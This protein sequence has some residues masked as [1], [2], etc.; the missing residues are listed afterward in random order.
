MTKTKQKI[1][2]DN[3]HVTVTVTCLEEDVSPHESFDDKETADKILAALER[4]PWA[5]CCVEVSVTYKGILKS[6]TY[7]G[8]CSYTDE[9]EFRR[10]SGY[11][12]LVGECLDD[13]NNQLCELNKEE[14]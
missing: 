2:K 3:K 1:T 10:D 8:G 12:E 11:Y 9:D 5:W 13:I 7:L 6:H 4:N 14:C